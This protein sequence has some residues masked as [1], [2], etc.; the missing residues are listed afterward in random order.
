MLTAGVLVLFAAAF[1]AGRYTAAEPDVHEV[2]RVVYR[3]QVVTKTRVVTVAAKA[4]TKRVVVYRDRVV[5]PDG[6]RIEREVERSD[7]ETRETT[8]TEGTTNTERTTEGDRTS[9]RTVTA[10]RPNWRVGALVGGQLDPLGLRPVYGAHAE[11]R[12]AG[13]FHVGAWGLHTGAGIAAG[14]SLSLEF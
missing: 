4:E 3:D 6:T 5:K 14:L 8:R 2:E 7:T 9:D 11:R 12:L 1:A 13:P 10:A